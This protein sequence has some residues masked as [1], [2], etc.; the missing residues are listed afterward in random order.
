MVFNDEAVVRR[1]AGCR[2]PVVSAVGHEIDVTL[3]D[4][5]AD[6]RAATPSQAAEMVVADSNAQLATL[7]EL[8]RRLLRGMRARLVEDRAHV[9]ML[10]ASFAE[11]RL[12]LAE[13]QQ[14]VDELTSRLEQG[15]RRVLARRKSEI[16][17]LHRRLAARHP[18]AVIANS[19]AKLGPLE[20]RLARAEVKGLDKARSLLAQRLGRLHAMSPLSVL[21]RGYAIATTDEGRAV[22]DPRDV[23]VGKK[24]TVRVHRGS[25]SAVVDRVD[26]AEGETREAEGPV[27]SVGSLPEEHS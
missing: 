4:L 22:R 2:V 14:R 19:R 5:A 9:V 15:K 18:R 20:V 1:V 3:T 12:G 10:S 11:Y 27:G 25:I 6:A 16:E 17:R 23:A 8:H 26:V 13:S 24:I 7:I 21:A